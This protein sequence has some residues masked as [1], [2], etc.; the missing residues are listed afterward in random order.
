[1]KLALYRRLALP[2]FLP[3]MSGGEIAWGRT[4]PLWFRQQTGRRWAPVLCLWGGLK[5][6]RWPWLAVW[7]VPSQGPILPSQS[8]QVKRIF[9]DCFSGSFLLVFF[10][11]LTP[12]I[13][14]CIFGMQFSSWDLQFQKDPFTGTS[15]FSPS[16]PFLQIGCQK[17]CIWHQERD[18][19]RFCHKA[20]G[21]LYLWCKK[22][23]V[24]LGFFLSPS[25]Q[26]SGYSVLQ[27]CSMPCFPGRE[28][29]ICCR[30]H[31]QHLTFKTFRE[32]AP[33]TMACDGSQ[34]PAKYLFPS[35]PYTL[36][37][38]T[39]LLLCSLLEVLYLHWESYPV[40][41]SRPDLNIFTWVSLA[42]SEQTRALMTWSKHFTSHA[43]SS[44][45]KGS[46]SLLNSLS[47]FPGTVLHYKGMG[48]GPNSWNSLTLMSGNSNSHQHQQH[49]EPYWPS[50]WVRAVSPFSF[51]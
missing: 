36:G 25:I 24:D 39:S 31:L 12:I 10:T 44:P 51:L 1:M 27:Y 16:L 9:T 18:R 26:G 23:R 11:W 8:W 35:V 46:L 20:D 28:G 19:S 3:N 42:L 41:I 48:S 43:L 49:R 33:A 6:Q 4:H 47:I 34:V 14:W 5:F 15:L 50:A 38:I 22:S 30:E 2:K 40:Y 37:L 29:G 17:I 45:L 7:S 13:E 32:P 21:G